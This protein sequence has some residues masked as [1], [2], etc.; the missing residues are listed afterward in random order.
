MVDAL[1]IGLGILAAVLIVA[2]IIAVAVVVAWVV[3]ESRRRRAYQDAGVSHLDLYFDEH[4]PDIARNFDL[5]S[6]SRFES[7]SSA[8]STRL[9]SLSKD[10]DT[11]GRARR[12]ID[13][14]M[15]R[16]EKRIAEVE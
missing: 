6:T 13:G 4:F 8:V 1:T 10:I 15:D 16:L 5:V 7:W 3:R 9:A 14:R 11:L 2:L 12:G